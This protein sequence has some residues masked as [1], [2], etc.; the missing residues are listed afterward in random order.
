MSI[1]SGMGHSGIVA[2]PIP[3][4]GGTGEVLTK[5]SPED[6]DMDWDPATGGAPANAEFVVM[7][8]DAT[9]TDER[10]LTAGTGINIVDGGAG[11]TV[12]INCDLTL[13]EAYNNDTTV[14]QISLNATPDPLTIDATVAG[15][16][17]AL[18]D[19]AN[20]DLVRFATTGSLIHGGNGSGDILGLRGSSDAGLG[21][22]DL[23]SRITIDFDYNDLVPAS[24]QIITYN[25][26]IPSSGGAVTS[27]MLVQPTIDIDSGLFIASTVRDI[28]RYDQNVAP[29]FAVQT[30]FLGQPAMRTDTATIQPNQSFM[31]ASQALYQ[32]DGAGN[33]TT[34]V[35]N[36]IGLTHNAQLRCFNSGDR[37]NVTNFTGVSV[38]PN[39]STVAGSFV[40]F[41]T[42]RGL[43][44]TNV[45]QG[46]FQPGAGTETMDAYYGVDMD[47]ITFDATAE[48]AVIRSALVANGSLNWFLLNNST[49]PS[50]FGTSVVH[51]DDNGVIQFG[52]ALNAAD[53]SL[54]WDG[55]QLRFF[56]FSTSDS[57]EWTSPS[58]D[59]FLFDNTAGSTD[60]EYNFNCARFSLGAQ[61][62]AVGNQTG[63][64]AT[65]ARTVPLAGSWAD[66]LLTQGGGLTIG[67]LAMSDVSAWTLNSIS[68]A[69]V[70]TGTIA[71]LNTLRIAGMTTSNP[72][73]TVTER[74][75]LY[76]TGRF[77]QRG[78][79]QYPSVNP[80][81][82][83]TGNNNNYAG[84]LTFS[85]SNS[86]RRWGRI[87]G[88]G[89]GTSVL[90]GIDSTAVQHGDTLDLTNIGTDT[91]T[92]TNQ[93]VASLAANRID[94][95]SWSGTLTADDSVT[96]RYDGTSG[97]WRVIGSQVP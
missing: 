27:F 97:F 10:V 65:P 33:V 24:Q 81:A 29:G 77:T 16:I 47:N 57:L 49:A 92:I 67:A 21:V 8:L 22:I 70:N 89:L 69:G 50:E 91:I 93:D 76:V 23:Q 38:G 20:A 88:D 11:S 78:L 96:I 2:I 26:T 30:V 79:V 14:P 75:A 31:F 51:H 18:R 90:T 82:L 53:V 58:A 5:Q 12:T 35:S 9:L 34:H 62:T 45:V 80:A 42:I 32:N 36:I 37:L 86:T 44:L 71:D 19:V 83:A 46:L 52:G 28:G 55:T 64:F 56:F 60:G 1:N 7:S 25:P 13:Q 48:K 63:V 17:F 61:T 43:R 39:Y 68:F 84:L 72:G 73:I 59:R 87:Q 66:F 40:D 4:D 15:D 41:G 95:G 85:A 6:Y 94:L 74:A 3:P 54:F